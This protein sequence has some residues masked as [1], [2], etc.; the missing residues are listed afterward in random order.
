M[1]PFPR[2]PA[3]SAGFTLI[4]IIVVV[5][6]FTIMAA[7]AYGGLNSVLRTKRAIE[8]SMKRTADMQRAFT[9]LRGD[10]QNLRD[11]PVRDNYGDVQPAFAFDREG[12]LSLVRGGWRTPVQTSRSS[13]ERVSYELKEGT[14]RRAS[15]G[16]LDLPQELDPVDLALLTQVEEVRWR[17]MDEARE[18]QTQWPVDSGLSDGQPS[19][20]PPI[21]VELVLVTKDWGETRFLFRTPMSG[22]VAS[23]SSADDGS[24]DGSGDGSGGS[25]FLTEGLLR[26]ELI[27]VTG[28]GLGGGDP[29]ADDGDGDGNPDGTPPSAGDDNGEVIPEQPDLNVNPEGEG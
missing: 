22:V 5:L 8:D 17:F 24:S 6:V 18:W 7:M 11:R 21:A 16:V 13:L 10:F 2:L 3:S 1:K 9:R 29:D 15:Y 27:G 26:A 23:G 25:G 12:A 14:L 28:G 19:G 20:P 4:E